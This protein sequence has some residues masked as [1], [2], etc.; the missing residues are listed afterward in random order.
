MEDWLEPKTRAAAAG[1]AM[2]AGGALFSQIALD[3]IEKGRGPF[4]AFGALFG[5]FTIWS[6]GIVAMVAGWCGL[7]GRARGPGHPALL[8]AS[9]VFILVVGAVYNT[10]L[11]GLNPPPTPLRALID[12]VF[13][14]ATPI[15]WPLWW[16]MLRP[17][18][19][20]GWGQ[21]WAVLP[22][23]LLYCAWS[24]WRGGVTGKYAYFFIDVSLLGW[25]KVGLNIVG[26]AALFAVL[27]AAAIAWDRRSR[28]RTF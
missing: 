9:S 10:L 19:R 23:P 5:F 17:R 20:L 2:L 3:M 1:I 12:H 24:L 14:I 7:V 6:N 13:H 21:L 25:A 15:L 11:V 4:E 22:V 28:P 18:R 8:A 27:M 26:F 16:L